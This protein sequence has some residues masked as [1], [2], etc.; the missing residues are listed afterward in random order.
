MMLDERYAHPQKAQVKVNVD[1]DAEGNLVPRYFW[2]ATE[3][4]EILRYKVELSLPPIN[5]VSYKYGLGGKK[6]PV[7]IRAVNS[8][9]DMDYNAGAPDERISALYLEDDKW[10]VPLTRQTNP[11]L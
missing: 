11:K 1:W 4:G 7:K 9:D 6:Y 8:D 10:Y 2:L 3:D 5:K